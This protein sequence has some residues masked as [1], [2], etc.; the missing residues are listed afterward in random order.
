MAIH[1]EIGKIGEDIASSF[2]TS[3]GYQVLFRNWRPLK[4]KQEV[5]VILKKGN[6]IVFV[7]VKTRTSDFFGEPEEYVQ[8]DKQRHL[9]QASHSFLAENKQEHYVEVRFDVVAVLL[10][11]TTHKLVSYRHLTNAFELQPFFY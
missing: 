7:E 10:T 5:D 3:E 1:N 8:A 11:K 9:I 6:T 2:L 4:G